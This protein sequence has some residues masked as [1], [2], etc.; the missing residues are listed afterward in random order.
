[1]LLAFTVVV[2]FAQGQEKTP[3][4]EPKKVVIFP[5]TFAENERGTNATAVQTAKDMLRKVFEER[6]KMEIIS[7]ARAAAAW[8][9]VMNERPWQATVEELG[10]LPGPI[11][12]KKLL[13]L[14]EVLGADYVCAGTVGWTVRSV[15]IGLGPKTKAY[16]DIN[17][18]IIDVKRGEV[19]LEQTAFRSDSN[20]A[21]KWYETAGAL[22]VAW[23][24][25][26]FSGGPKTPQMQRAAQ[27][28]LGAA[29]DPFFT[30]GNRK[31]GG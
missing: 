8:E 13:K 17:L 29:T 2:S 5:W 4:F 10:Q 23:G 15:W 31:I 24:I 26:L 27:I 12:P 9:Q 20:K 19:A 30:S 28:G 1:L 14:G 18:Q 25:T 22:F 16:C 7:E 6:G 3:I 11:D 21:E